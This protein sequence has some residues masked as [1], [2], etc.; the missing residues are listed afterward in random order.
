MTERASFIADKR[1]PCPTHLM[2]CMAFDIGLGRWE[3]KGDGA[4]YAEARTT[5]PPSQIADMKRLGIEVP[6]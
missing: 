1:T 6:E 2:R 3:C 5:Y 4:H